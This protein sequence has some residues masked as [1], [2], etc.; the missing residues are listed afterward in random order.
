[1]RYLV[2]VALLA[3]QAHA[4]AQDVAVVQGTVRDATGLMLPGAAVEVDER[5]VAVSDAQGHCDITLP[6]PG[7]VA[8]R[9]LL[10][11]FR[12]WESRVDATATS[13]LDIVL[14]IAR[15]RDRITVT[16]LPPEQDVAPVFTL[17]PTHVYRTP[18]AQADVFQALQRSPAS[19]AL[20]REP[21][22]SC[23]AAT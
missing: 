22:C 12:V 19:R 17:E 21:A 20:T 10:P 8:V 18:G 7:V 23:A 13:T 5:L 14:E 6:T 15:L 16:P 3:C 11:G 9:V 1:M 2:F 4:Q